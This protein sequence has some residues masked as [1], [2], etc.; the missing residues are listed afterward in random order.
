MAVGLI[1]E[2]IVYRC[3]PEQPS[4]TIPNRVDLLIGRVKPIVHNWRNNSVVIGHNTNNTSRGDIRGEVT[5][6]FVEVEG[7]VVTARKRRG[8]RLHVSGNR[9][10]EPG[11]KIHDY[12][13]TSVTKC[14]DHRSI[15]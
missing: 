2:D 6:E 4:G 12:V 9:C 8:F 7:R 5:V 3:S 10:K 14:R 1:Q 11:L 15:V 13:I